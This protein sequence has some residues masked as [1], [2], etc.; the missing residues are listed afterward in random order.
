M[1]SYWMVAVGSV[2]LTGLIAGC[3]NQNVS[4]GD[5]WIGRDEHGLNHTRAAL[6]VPVQPLA[7]TTEPST[8]VAD[9][10]TT[11]PITDADGIFF[12]VAIS[13]GGSRSA[14]FSAS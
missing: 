14:N 6:G 9:R 12:G 4:L 5:M 3:T 1:R 10:P 13:G 2:V 8:V 11:A 7:A